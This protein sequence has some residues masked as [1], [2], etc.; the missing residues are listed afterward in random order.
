VHADV[1]DEDAVVAAAV[2]VDGVCIRSPRAE[3]REARKGL[4]VEKR[5]LLKEDLRMELLLILLW[6]S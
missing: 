4:A 6:L 5:R 2:R 1:S 3:S